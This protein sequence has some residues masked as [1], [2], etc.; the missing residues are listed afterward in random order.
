MKKLYGSGVNIQSAKWAKPEMLQVVDG[1]SSTFRVPV[2]RVSG[3]WPAAPMAPG[4][5]S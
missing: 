2:S 5:T 1:Q 3:K 4:G